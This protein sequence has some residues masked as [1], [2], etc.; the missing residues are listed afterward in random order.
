LFNYPVE[1]DVLTPHLP[2]GLQL[3]RWQGKAHVSLVAFDFLDTRVL[4]IPWPGFRNF[5]EINLRFYVTDGERRGVVFIREYVPQRWVAWMARTLYNEP[6][7]AAPM[8][9]QRTEHKEGICIQHT[10]TTGDTEQR[11]QVMASGDP[12]TP[13][14]NS[15]EHHFKEHQWGFGTSRKGQRLVYEVRHPHWEIIPVTD[16][17]L[18]WSWDVAYGS[19]WAFL[20]ATKPSSVVFALGSEIEVYPK[21]VGAD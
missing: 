11:L 19:Q 13:V 14:E 15:Q 7:V 8:H 2:P 20:N 9:S 18:D 6:Y 16:F 5:P 3:D 1:D 21:K 10:L 4:G 17:Q 12:I